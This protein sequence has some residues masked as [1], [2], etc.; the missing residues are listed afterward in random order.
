MLPQRTQAVAEQRQRG[1]T[2]AHAE[3]RADDEFSETNAGGA[4]D[5]IDDGERCDR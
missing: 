3:H 4:R 2:G 1:D 5:D